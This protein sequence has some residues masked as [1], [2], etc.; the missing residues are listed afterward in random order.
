MDNQHLDYFQLSEAAIAAVDV[1]GSGDRD[2]RRFTR[3]RC[4]C[5]A[6]LPRVAEGRT[7]PQNRVFRD[8]FGIR[9]RGVPPACAAVRLTDPCRCLGHL[10]A[11][12]QRNLATPLQRKQDLAIA[13][14]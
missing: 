8:C 14:S 9:A 2:V 10:T 6:R 7:S 11:R 5:F 12:S 3:K 13:D 1:A 4:A